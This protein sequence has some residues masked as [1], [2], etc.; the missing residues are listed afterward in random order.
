MKKFLVIF[1]VLCCTLCAGCQYTV[2]P[3]FNISYYGWE[4]E[5]ISLV[6]TS[7]DENYFDR[8]YMG[9]LTVEGKT[10][11]IRIVS[12]MFFEDRVYYFVFDNDVVEEN[13]RVNQTLPQ[14]ERSSDYQD[15]ELFIFTVELSDGNE[16]LTFTVHYDYGYQYGNYQTDYTG[17]VFA[18]H[19]L[20]RAE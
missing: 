10:Y 7:D 3:G 13:I 6:P 16:A 1:L 20:P 5:N 9:E 14:E 18:L 2:K 8:K 11:R 17:T 19:R 12:E 15:A 4:G